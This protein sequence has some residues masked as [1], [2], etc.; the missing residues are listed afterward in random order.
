MNSI[1]GVG[2]IGSQFIS[3][4][5]A[6]SLQQCPR[7]KMLAVCS[8]TPGNAEGFAEQ[9]DIPHRFTDHRRML[10]TMPTQRAQPSP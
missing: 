3:T 10:E 2:L 7:A 6:K 1:V 4:I 5:H 8:P 9:F